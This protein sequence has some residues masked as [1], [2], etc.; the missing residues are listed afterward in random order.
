MLFT[1]LPEGAPHPRPVSRPAASARQA[2]HGRHPLPRADRKGGGDVQR[3]RPG[4]APAARRLRQSAHA[5]GQPGAGA[6]EPDAVHLDREAA[7]RHGPDGDRHS[8]DH[9]GAEPDLLRHAA[10]SRHRHGARDQ[11]QHRRH[12]GAASRSLRRPR[13]RAVPGAGTRGRGT[14]TAAPLAWPARDRDR[15]QRRRRRSVGG[16]VSS[17]LRQ[18]RGTRPDVL[19]ASDRLH[20]GAA[21]RRSLLYQCDRQS[22]GYHGRGA[23]PDLRRRAGGVPATEAGTVA[24]RRLPAGLFRPH[25]SRGIGPAGL[26]RANSRDA[27][28]LF[29]TAVFRYAGLY[30]SAT[31]I[32]GAGIRR[33]PCADGH[34]LSRRHGRDRSDRLHRRCRPVSPPPNA[35]R[36]WVATRRGCWGSRRRGREAAGSRDRLPLPRP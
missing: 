29:E 19:H 14:G 6:A 1:C 2:P 26:L 31:G 22:V 16:P 36:Y 35:P 28:N 17:D 15:H 25:R 9:A 32:S 13:H 12:R 30:A 4:R 23:S 24:W 20:R 11:R 27:D 7:R 21:L 3:G 5:R 34:R 8:G 18:S 10:G 33:R